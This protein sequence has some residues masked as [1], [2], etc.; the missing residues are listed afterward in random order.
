MPIEIFII[1]V[2]VGVAPLVACGLSE[3]ELVEGI[4]M[5]FDFKGC[6]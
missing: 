4:G 6:K 5:G 2:V 1:A 3:S